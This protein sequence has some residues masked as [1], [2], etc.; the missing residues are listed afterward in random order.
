MVTREAN[1]CDLECRLAG[2]AAASYLRQF[3]QAAPKMVV[4]QGGVVGWTVPVAAILEAIN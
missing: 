3:K 2:C 4:A 1:D